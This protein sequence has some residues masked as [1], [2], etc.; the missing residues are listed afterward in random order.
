MDKKIE[1]NRWNI[2]RMSFYA[3]GLIAFAFFVSKIYKDSG[4][5]RLNVEVERLLID[6]ISKGPFQEFIPIS[7][8]VQPIKTVFLGAIE[9]G[10]VEE[11]FVE[12]GS[13]VRKGEAV[14]QLSNSDLEVSYLNQEANIVSQ[15]NSI[16]N[17]SIMM[18]QQSLNLQE[19][20]LSV[21]FRL[22]QLTKIVDRNAQLFKDNVIA[23]VEYEDAMDEYEHLQRR[24][25]LMRKNITKDSLFQ[26]FQGEQMESTLDL[27][28]R[29]L[30][31]S[32]KSLDNLTIRAPIDGQLSSLDKEIGELI[33]KGEKIAQIDMLNNF[34][35]KATIDQFYISRIFIGQE[36]SFS[37]A[38]EQHNLVIKKIYPEVTNGSFEVDLVFTSAPPQSIKR[39]Q[40]LSIKLALSSETQA[41]LLEKGSF[42]QKTG[43]NWAYVIDPTSGK[44]V[45]RSIKI[46]RQS[47]TYFEVLQ[48]LSPGDIV[49]TSS[50]ENYDDKDEL[51]LK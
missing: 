12:D 15:I 38:G 22:D 27:M 34:K 30:A 33:T 26:K 40:T 29:N 21:D 1:N 5:S 13:M 51:I 36:G 7:G 39:G 45:K 10:R 37:F 49:I 24:K 50:Y 28:K 48:G 14:L 17:T 25:I 47:P 23:Q 9:G 4:T 19:Q 32:R 2:P 20:S 31:I 16:R 8:N 35:V 18:E 44:A 41:I 11:I 46:G 3:I 43:G 42:Y 6:T